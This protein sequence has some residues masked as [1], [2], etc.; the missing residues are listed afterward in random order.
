M[1]TAPILGTDLAQPAFDPQ[2]LG[3]LKAGARQQDAATLRSVAQEFEALLLTQVMKSMRAASFGDDLF[4][5]AAT[6][7]FTSLLDGQYAQVLSRRPGLGLA[8]AIVRQ[9]ELAGASRK[10][11][12]VP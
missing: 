10:P 6:Q 7:T 12:V 1:D 8:D 11:A 5:S 3:R 2:R 4:G 9:I